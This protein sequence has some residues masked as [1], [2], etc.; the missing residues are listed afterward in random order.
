MRH[1]ESLE[2]LIFPGNA[3]NWTEVLLTPNK[4]NIGIISPT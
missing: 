4:A 3:L 1:S 2:V